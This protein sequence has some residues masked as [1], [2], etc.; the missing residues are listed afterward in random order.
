[1][2]GGLDGD[3]AAAAAPASGVCPPA[4]TANGGETTFLT[5]GLFLP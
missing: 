5:A 4:C 3:L 1:M 2:D